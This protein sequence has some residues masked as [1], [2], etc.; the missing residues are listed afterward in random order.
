LAN[1]KSAKK[2]ARQ[3]ITKTARNSQAK[4]TIRTFE[5]KLRIAIKEKKADDA[6]SLLVTYTSKMD[7]AAQKGMLHANNAARKIGRLAK[8][9]HAIVK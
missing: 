2:R 3:T 7:K 9:V 6:K 4:K 5:K 1:H 8:A